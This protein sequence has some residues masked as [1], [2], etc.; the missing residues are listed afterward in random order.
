[1]QADA[2]KSRGAIERLLIEHGRIRQ[3]AGAIGKIALSTRWDW[4]NHSR[5]GAVFNPKE[6]MS[7][8]L[9]AQLDKQ[10]KLK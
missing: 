4:Q 9:K 6:I 1:V 3:N 10:E 7:N 5:A 2:G 8:F